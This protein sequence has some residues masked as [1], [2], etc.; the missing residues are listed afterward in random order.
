MNAVQPIE[1]SLVKYVIWWST[2]NDVFSCK[3]QNLS[4]IL[5]NFFAD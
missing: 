4:F 1:M 3:K 2:Q 5:N